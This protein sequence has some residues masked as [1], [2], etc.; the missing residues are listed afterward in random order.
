MAAI[1]QQLCVGKMKL[2]QSICDRVRS[3]KNMRKRDLVDVGNITRR[4]SNS[5][6]QREG[7]YNHAPLPPLPTI[8]DR[9]SS[10][11][12]PT[13]SCRSSFHST[14]EF[15]P[16]NTP[17]FIATDSK[18]PSS[19]PNLSI[20]FDTFPCTFIL[21]DFN[22]VS[23]VNSEALAGLGRL[24]R[25]RNSE[26]FVPLAQFLYPQLDAQ[27]ASHGRGLVGTPQST[28]SRFAVDVLHQVYQ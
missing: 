8:F 13:L 23:N 21:N 12:H 2:D 24:S 6:P 4:A 9:S 20:F 22:S 1:W 18:L 27:I 3:S 10:L 5:R 25:L 15:L 7:A 19:D 17:L 11:L 26:D 28:Y 14:P 16:F